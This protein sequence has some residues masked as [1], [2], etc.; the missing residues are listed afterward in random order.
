[1]ILFLLIVISLGIVTQTAIMIYNI[2]TNKNII[3]Y[4]YLDDGK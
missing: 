3:N 1:M 2:K 4:K